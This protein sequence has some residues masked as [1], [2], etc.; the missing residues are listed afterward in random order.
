MHPYQ[1]RRDRV[2]DKLLA[3][4]GG[5]AVLLT[6]SEAPRNRDSYYPFRWDSYFYY[7]T[8]FQ[9]PEAALVI[10]AGATPDSKPKSILFCRSK[11][12]EREIWDG[13]RFGPAAAREHFG[14]DEA[15]PIEELDARLPDLIANQPSIAYP[16][17]NDAQTDARIQAALNQ[18]RSQARAGVAVPRSATDIRVLIDDMRLIKDEIEIDIMRRAANISAQ[19]HTRAMQTTRA[20]MY[21]YQVEAE[22]LHEFKR[23]GSQS[24]AYGSIVAGGAN[25]CILH[26]HENNAALQKGQLLLIDAGCELDGYASDITR[27]FPVG[28]KFSGPQRALYEIVLA[29]QEAAIHATR[30]GE[31]FMAPHDAAVRVLAQG[32]IDTGLLTGS[33]DGV[34]ES[35][36]Y[37][38]FYMHRTG[39]WL[40]MDVHDCGDYRE[41]GAKQTQADGTA[42]WRQLMPGMVLTV[43]P[44]IYVRAADDVLPAFHNIGI[45]IEDD[46]LVTQQGCEILSAQVVKSVAD[47]E[48]LMA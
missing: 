3:Q 48:A 35:G 10:V 33:L 16:L 9:E 46:A 26:Y 47:I 12:E 28:G 32:M 23:A 15:Y 31:H 45:R 8:G 4:G 40:G 30:P 24:P 29:S 38:R 5:V 43:E 39:H 41:R 34:I 21:E 20:G 1:Q 19:A 37:K 36:A 27:T 44:G 25:A 14:F 42:P 13:F 22:L 18:V 17:A 7:L 11:N 2:I 6:A